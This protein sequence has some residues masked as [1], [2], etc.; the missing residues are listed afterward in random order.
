MTT[1]AVF[2]VELFACGSPG[3]EPAVDAPL[4]VGDAHRGDSAADAAPIFEWPTCGATSFGLYYGNAIAVASD[5]TVLNE[6]SRRRAAA[7][8]AS[9]PPRSIASSPRTS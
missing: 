9:S 2:I 7:R 8:A 6:H 5:G 1:R 3:A 4:E